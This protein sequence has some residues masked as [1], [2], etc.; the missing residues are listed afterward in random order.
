M[1][2]AVRLSPTAA[3]AGFHD[4]HQNDAAAAEEAPL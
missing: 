4:Q 3:A 2:S 1:H